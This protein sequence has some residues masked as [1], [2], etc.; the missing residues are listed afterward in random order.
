[1]H[2]YVPILSAALAMALATGASAQQRPPIVG[3][4]HI[5]LKTADLAGAREFYG[6]YLGYQEAFSISNPNGTPEVT[7]FKVND[8]QYIEVFPAAPSEAEGQLSHVAFETTNAE[9]LRVYLASRGVVVPAELR[10]LPDGNLSFVIK[11]PEGHSIEFVQYV[12]TGALGRTFGKFEPASRISVHIGHVGFTVK[13]RDAEDRLFRDILGFHEVW[14]GGFKAEGPWDW[15]AMR[16]P[17]GMDHLEYMLNVHDASPHTLGVMN[18]VCL[19]VPSVYA[20]YKTLIERGMKID[21]PPKTG[22]DGKRQLNLY[23]PNLTRTE[24]M[25]P[26]PVEKPCC[27]TFLDK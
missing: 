7:Y 10:T 5:A 24:L 8:R 18:H 25:E 16:V 26:K 4:A 3:V 2:R 23:D 22:L 15:V 12:M 19:I 6:N 20:S 13:D 11:D 9:Q 21:Q 14:H 27:S 17:D 1:M